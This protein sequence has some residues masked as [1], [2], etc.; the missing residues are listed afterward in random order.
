MSLENRYKFLKKMYPSK[1]ILIYYDKDIV[2]CY[3]DKKILKYLNNDL[4][5]IRKANISYLLLDGLEIIENNNFKNN[6]YLLYKKKM[7]INE[8]LKKGCT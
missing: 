8:I 3:I 7:I 4:T 1:L 6:R 2:S 5:K